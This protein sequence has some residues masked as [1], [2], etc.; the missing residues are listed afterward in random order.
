MIATNSERNDAYSLGEDADA[1]SRQEPDCLTDTSLVSWTTESIIKQLVDLRKRRRIDQMG[2]A[3]AIGMSQGMVSKME[4]MKTRT[5]L[6][7]ALL[8]ANAIGANITVGRDNGK[9]KRHR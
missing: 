7:E 4:T 3:R 5:S 2:V 8:Y 9:K 1:R 6:E